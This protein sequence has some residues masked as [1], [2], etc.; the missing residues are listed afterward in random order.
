[1]RRLLDD[2]ATARRVAL[3]MG[4][5]RNLLLWQGDRMVRVLEFP[6]GARPVP[7][8]EIAAKNP[9]VREFLRRL[10]ELTEPPFDV[11][12]PGALAAFTRAAAMDVVL[13]VRP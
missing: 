6:D 10:G 1:M 2:E 3:A 8:D 9:D 7:I 12:R 13:D 4:A 11:D 5:S